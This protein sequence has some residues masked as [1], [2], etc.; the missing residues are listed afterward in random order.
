MQAISV[1]VSSVLLFALIQQSGP[2]LEENIFAT[3]ASS[4]LLILLLISAAIGALSALSMDIS[5]ERVKN[6]I[7]SLFYIFLISFFRQGLDT[8]SYIE[9]RLF[10]THEH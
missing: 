3:R 2:E 7:F 5:V 1:G 6:I 8:Y 10:T 9:T 4:I